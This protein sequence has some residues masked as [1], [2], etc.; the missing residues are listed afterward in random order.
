MAQQQLLESALRRCCLAQRKLYLSLRK[1]K[2]GAVLGGQPRSLRQHLLRP[3]GIVQGQQHVGLQLRRLR[4]EDAV[5][6]AVNEAAQQGLGG[7]FVARIVAG[8][9]AQKISVVGQLLAG[10]PRQAQA[11]L[12]LSI[13]LVQQISVAQ[14]QVSRRGR[15]AAVLARICGHARVSLRG[16]HRGQLLGHRPQFGRGHKSLLDPCRSGRPR[17]AA[18]PACAAYRL[19][20]LG[21]GLFLRLAV[22]VASAFAF[23]A[24]E[25]A[26]GVVEPAE[27]CPATGSTTIRMERS[28]ARHRAAGRAMETGEDAALISSLYSA[29]PPPCRA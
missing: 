18:G 7:S 14:R 25:L 28:P 10:L 15:L 26:E 11:R 13:A 9:R 23:V 8:L 24:D 5:R 6:I 21:S 16:A 22:P 20:A 1:L 12:G 4:I 2:A 27:V 17:R 29:W 19:A 3:G